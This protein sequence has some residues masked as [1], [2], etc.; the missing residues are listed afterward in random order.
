MTRVEIPYTLSPFSP[1]AA[2]FLVVC[3]PANFRFIA[4]LPFF[5]FLCH[6]T[7]PK[8]YIYFSVIFLLLPFFRNMSQFASVAALVRSVEEQPYTTRCATFLQLGRKSLGATANANSSDLQLRICEMAAPTE[9]SYHRLLSAYALCGAFAEAKRRSLLVPQPLWQAALVVLQDRSERTAALIMTPLLTSKAP[10]PSEDFSP[11][12]FLASSRL[13]QFK[14]F[15]H[16]LLQC[17]KQDVVVEVYHSRIISHP[18]KQQYLLGGLPPA[19][20]ER[21]SEEDLAALDTASL[22][23]LCQRHGAWVVEFLCRRVASQ[24][25]ATQTV[26]AVWR[27]H[28]LRAIGY[29]SSHGGARHALRL[30]T[31]TTPFMALNP[32]EMG[33]LLTDYF[34]SKFPVEVASY[35]LDGEG[36]AVLAS[37]SSSLECILTRRGVRRLK[38]KCD[39]ILQMMD[40]GILQSIRRERPHLPAEVRQRLYHTQRHLMVDWRGVM[41]VSRVEW[42]PRAE[43][44]VAEARADFAHLELRDDTLC[45][46]AFLRFLPF[47]EILQLGDAFLTSNDV[48]NR[49]DALL[50]LLASLRYF[51]EHVDAALD[52][53]L[54]RTKEQDPWKIAMY[55]ALN[56]L[57]R[58]FWRRASKF[59]ADATVVEKLRLLLE[60][61]FNAN[62][63]SDY[64][65]GTV[66]VLLLDLSG[67]YPDFAIPQLVHLI[68]QESDFCSYGNA[69]KLLDYLAIAYPHVLP[70]LAT[71]LLNVAL[72][73]LR[74]SN[75]HLYVEI[76]H[77]LLVES[78]KSVTCLF[79][80]GQHEDASHAARFRDHVKTV[81]TAGRDCE[82]G[83]AASHSFN[84]LARLFPAE[85]VAE[86]PALIEK[87]LDWVVQD[88]VQRM[89]CNTL[90][91]PLLDRLVNLIVEIPN[92]RFHY[93]KNENG[94]YLCKLPLA[95][96]YKWTAQ[97][98]EMYAVSIL[99]MIYNEKNVN[100]YP[101]RTYVSLLSQLP[102][103]TSTTAWADAKGVSHS[104]L[105]L[106]TEE[107][108]VHGDYLKGFALQALGYYEGDT[109]AVRV[110]QAALDVADTR[111]EALR[112]L[113][114]VLRRASSAEAVRG[115][116]PILTGRHVSSQKEALHLLGGKREEAAFE[117][118]VRFAAEQQLPMP[119]VDAEGNVVAE[120]DTPAHFSSSPTSAALPMH[121]DVRAAF[122]T[123]LFHYIT[124][125]RVWAYYERLV[126]WDMKHAKEAGAEDATAED[127][128]NEEA[129]DE[130]EE[131]EEENESNEEVTDEEEEEEGKSEKK[132]D[133]EEALRCPSSAACEAM[134][135]LRWTALRLPWQ[136]ARYQRLLAHL[137][138]H[139]KRN[140]RVAALR[141]LA[142]VPPYTSLELCKEVGAYLDGCTSP[143]LVRSALQCM[144]RCTA[145]ETVAYVV[146]SILNVQADPSLKIV[147]KVFT[148]LTER[149]D[150]ISAQRYHRVAEG[151]IMGL[152]AARRQPKLIV[153]FV[154]V[155]PYVQLV[156]QLM[157]LMD[158]NLLH[159]GAAMRAVELMRNSNFLL[160]EVE[161]A[162][163]FEASVLRHHPAAVVRRIG[164]EVVLRCCNDNGWTDERRA[165]VAEYKVDAD[166]WVS[167]D[168]S[169]VRMD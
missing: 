69:A 17:G 93:E 113:A 154:Y 35:L 52:Y 128:S 42:L 90:Q 78:Q 47:P 50:P 89:V 45:R 141:K 48:H 21:L 33:Y 79:F 2:L 25:A 140:V 61:T 4:T 57:P 106:A 108:P 146:S 32:C 65:L 99:A 117:G 27:R 77:V 63:L 64:T 96:A 86:L 58:G 97:Q 15:L 74:S 145:E 112:A 136:L 41:E 144:M 115:L 109:A 11:A 14:A 163:T 138:R 75:D 36:A 91:G 157:A 84:L 169:L 53:C 162:D 100:P 124:K 130:E 12:A 71:E 105:A 119:D 81:L 159:I 167:S 16:K 10:Q 34:L 37:F 101:L 28:V 20:I 40:K 44:R 92:C 6:L 55:E 164:L 1:I 151:T 114:H 160:F 134:T 120:E 87:N 147:T 59:V 66:Q 155:L 7:D 152:I 95:R 131:E 82:I 165:A 29:L 31:F 103:V 142:D 133:D 168:A 38:G 104:L 23:M 54:R 68:R 56:G 137:L 166:A 161:D 8:T 94:P 118:L 150:P 126:E 49:A 83:S 121:R 98:Q 102:S 85:T 111:M 132:D 51:P 73:Q 153:E 149:A 30:F 139:P 62:D 9:V 125:P 107:H 5:F 13:P 135:K 116:E 76:T 110:L 123:T 143:R 148:S 158:A 18:V 129:T 19:E 39:L 46:I 80:D 156:P 122:V 72:E 127:E 3:Q 26:E 60:A 67:P 43:D 88:T 70:R 22:R 24:F